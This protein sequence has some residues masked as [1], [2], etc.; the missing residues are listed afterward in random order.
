[1]K[2]F[3][4]ICVNVENLGEVAAEFLQY[5]KVYEVEKKYFNEA[6]YLVRHN[7]IQGHFNSYRFVSIE[8]Y[9]KILIK[10]RYEQI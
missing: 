5:G 2:Y 7:G 4:V 6:S 3:K 10:Q 1:M 8:E 9:K